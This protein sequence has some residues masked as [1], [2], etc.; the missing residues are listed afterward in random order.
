[1]SA[2]LLQSLGVTLALAIATTALLM[3]LAPPLAWWLARTESAARPFVEALVAVPLVLPPT[4]LGFYLLLAFAGDGVL[5]SLWIRLTGESLAFT[6]TALVIGSVIYSLPFVSQPVAASFRTTDAG[7]MD[8]ASL[9]G[10]SP[11]R[12]FVRIVLPLH[13]RALTAGGVLGFAHTVGEFGIVLMIG[14]NIPGETRVLSILLFD[15]VE[16]LDYEAAHITAAL[17]LAFALVT[18]TATY[19]LMRR[20]R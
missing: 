20:E 11:F 9:L 17:L 4:V 10:M 14:G 7:L 1:V 5:G 18:L 6:F 13:A 3:L 2:D 15:Q 8:A 19:T 12:R 16:T